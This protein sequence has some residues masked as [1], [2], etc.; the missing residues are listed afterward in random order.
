MGELELCRL[1][2]DDRMGFLQGSGLR[3]SVFNNLVYQALEVCVQG[4]H[5]IIASLLA[6]GRVPPSSIVRITPL[7][8]SCGDP[9][10]GLDF[11]CDREGRCRIC[12]EDVVE[13]LSA[14]LIANGYLG[15]GFSG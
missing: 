4:V 1:Q 5:E 13:S 11:M 2:P 14:L 6:G 9:E 7:D 15:E 3:E 12:D 8:E 10:A